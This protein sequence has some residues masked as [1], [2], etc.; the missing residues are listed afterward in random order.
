MHITVKGSKYNGATISHGRAP[1]HCSSVRAGG[2]HTAVHHTTHAPLGPHFKPG[3]PG[4]TNDLH[5]SG[6]SHKAEYH[7]RRCITHGGT[8]DKVVDHTRHSTYL[9]RVSAGVSAWGTIR[10]TVGVTLWGEWG[11]GGSV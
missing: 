5:P 8:P 1:D 9:L 3:G 11:G 4:T 6:A 10:V 2:A 7:T